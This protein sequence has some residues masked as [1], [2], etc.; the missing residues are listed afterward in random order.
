MVAQLRSLALGKLAVD[1][2]LEPGV[3]LVTPHH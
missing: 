2:G 1:N 3:D